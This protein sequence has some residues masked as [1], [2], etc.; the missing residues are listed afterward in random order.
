MQRVSRFGLIPLMCLMMMV[1][2]VPARAADVIKIG[3]IGPM[4]FNQGTNIWNGAEMGADEINAKGG[5]KVGHKKMEIEL[6]QADSKEFTAHPAVSAKVMEELITRD[7][8]N[9]VIG[10]FRSEAV[11]AMQD[12][13]MNHK[14]LFFGVG[15]ADPELCDRVVKNYDRYKYWFRCSPQD[16]RDLTKAA[17][18]QLSGVAALLKQRLKLDRTKVAILAEKAMWAN[19]MVK[20]A[21]VFIPKMGME[22]AG[23]WRCSANAKNVTPELTAIR[24]SR[25]HIILTALSGPVGIT[26]SKEAGEMKIPAVQVG[27]NVESAKDS[28]WRSTDGMANYA[29]ALNNYVHGVE[30]NELTAPFVEGYYKRFGELPMYTANS[31]AVIT[32]HLKNAIEAAG[33][34]NAERLIPQLEKEVVKTPDGVDAFKKDEQGRQTHS[35]RFGP[36]YTTALGVQWQ[37]GKMVAVWP[38]FKWMSPCWEFS[39]QPPDKPNKMSY[40]GLEPFIIPPWMVAAYKK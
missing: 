4:Q 40:K 29:M 15:A 3:V 8:V 33:T 39:A 12:V 5:I 18:L 2:I 13:A 30:Y 9:F 1:L 35:I 24:E 34:L 7:K 37:D 20:A 21:E 16:S 23:T 36:G 6:F 17:F 38:H 32:C 31:Y 11:L 22:V 10:G 25:A 27:I 28:F 19:S 14:V 26:V